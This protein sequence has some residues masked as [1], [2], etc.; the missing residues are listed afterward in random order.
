LVLPYVP[1]WAGPVWQL[2]VVRH[3]RRD[4]LQQ[5]LTAMG[6][7]TL[8]H[9]SVPPH[10][11]G[12]YADSRERFGPLPLTEQIASTILSVPIGPHLT[13]TDAYLVTDGLLA[14]AHRSCLNLY[15]RKGSRAP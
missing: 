5:N 2:F 1:A 3:P 9:Y 6:I 13:T 11:S 8:I 12:I 4:R 14:A 15:E 10:L 7:G